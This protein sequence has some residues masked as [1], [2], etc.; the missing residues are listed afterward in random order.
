MK[1]KHSQNK[2]QF[3]KLTQKELHTE[4]MNSSICLKENE[5]V[6]KSLPAKKTQ[7]PSGFM[8]DFFKNNKEEITL[9]L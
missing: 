8:C 3:I 6:I 5:S 1:Q 9:N 4:N 2:R 7:G